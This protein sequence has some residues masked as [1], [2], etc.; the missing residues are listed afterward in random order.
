MGTK[1]YA[2]LSERMDLGDL[3]FEHFVDYKRV[4]A[5]YEDVAEAKGWSMRYPFCAERASSC[6]QSPTVDQIII[7]NS[8]NSHRRPFAMRR[9][10]WY[11]TVLTLLTMRTE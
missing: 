6:L 1:R 9:K 10:A 11:A 4:K 7:I 3:C 5:R 8:L 2:H